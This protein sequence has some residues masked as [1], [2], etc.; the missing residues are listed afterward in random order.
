LIDTDYIKY[1]ENSETC[2]KIIENSAHKFASSI[3][4]IRDNQAALIFV[5][6]IY[7][8]ERSKYINI[9]YYYIRDLYKS[10]CIC[11]VFV[12]SAKIV[13]NRLT[14]LLSKNKFKIFVNQLKMQ[15]LRNNKSQHINI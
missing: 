6:D 4:L 1:L 5:K 13:A 3:Q 7:I 8:Y 11:V 15:N 12:L 2:I 10:D 9:V 14:K